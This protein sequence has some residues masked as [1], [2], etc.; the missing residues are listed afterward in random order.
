MAGSDE[1]LEVRVDSGS[2]DNVVVELVRDEGTKE[3]DHSG[4]NRVD[5]VMRI[6]VSRDNISLYVDFLGT[7]NEVNSTGL[8]VRNEELREPGN[9][10]D[11]IIDGQ[12][13]KFYVGDVVWVRTKSQTWWPGKIFDP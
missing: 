5:S 3:Y 10:E 4:I 9:G 8:M 2:D 1:R 13:H 7:L 12:E 11:L 6:Q